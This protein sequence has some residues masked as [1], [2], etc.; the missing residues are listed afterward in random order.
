MATANRPVRYHEDDNFEIELIR[1]REKI[2]AQF[3][4]LADCL[5]RRER[6]KTVG[7]YKASF[8]SHLN[9]VEVVRVKLKIWRNNL[10]TGVIDFPL[11]FC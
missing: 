5:K 6:E 4:D 7:C 3:G 1:A 9:E 2:I 8:R 10:L 11:D